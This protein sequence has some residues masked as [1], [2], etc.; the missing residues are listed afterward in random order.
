MSREKKSGGTQNEALKLKCANE[1]LAVGRAEVRDAGRQ[2]L[3]PALLRR[4]VRRVL[5][6][7]QRADRRG[8][9]SDVARR[10]TLARNRL[11][12]LLCDLSYLA[13]RT[14]FSAETRGHLLQHR[15]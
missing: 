8:S 10:P 13:A 5:R 7:L 15:L 14:T 9:G 11:L 12:L 3:L 4:V 6:Q 2:A 1:R